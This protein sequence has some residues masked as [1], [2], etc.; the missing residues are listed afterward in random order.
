MSKS[1]GLWANI[2][3]KRR[4]IANGS[5]EKMRRPGEEGAPTAEALHKSAHKNNFLTQ[6]QNSD[7]LFKTGET[8]NFMNDAFIRGFVKQAA[9]HGLTEAEAVAILK[10][11]GAYRNTHAGNVRALDDLIANDEYVRKNHP[12]QYALN[13]LVP[14]PLREIA[15]RLTRRGEAAVTNHPIAGHLPFAGLV[16]GGAGA[17][18]RARGYDPSSEDVAALQAKLQALQGG[19]GLPQ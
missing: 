18:E 11:A 10:E 2:H 4:R 15:H 17:Q 9:S 3:A 7:K 14:G 6:N 8:N 1:K 5:G 16:A 12:V 13:P 19:A